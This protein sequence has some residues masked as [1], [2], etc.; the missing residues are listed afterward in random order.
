MNEKLKKILE[1]TKVVLKHITIYTVIISACIAS[2][3][4]GFYYEKNYSDDNKDRVVKTITKKEVNLA[5]DFS[6]NLIIIDNKTGDYTIYEDSIGNT[7]FTL[8]AKNIWG[9][10]NQSSEQI[11]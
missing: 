9:Q 1:K 5:I 8:Y 10:H 2:F 4:L 7:I 6:N 11:K 3:F